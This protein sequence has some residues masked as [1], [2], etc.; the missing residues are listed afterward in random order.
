M[1]RIASILRLQVHQARKAIAARGQLH[2]RFFSSQVLS[3]DDRKDIVGRFGRYQ[4]EYD[5][6]LRDKSGF[7][8]RAASGELV[9]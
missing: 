3:Q 5:E 2:N 4:D 8:L 9:G 7:W 1:Y 6:S